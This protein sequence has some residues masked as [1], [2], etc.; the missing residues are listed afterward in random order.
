MNYSKNYNKIS[1]KDKNYKYSSKI[2]II[3]MDNIKKI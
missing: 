2:N 1:K 3:K